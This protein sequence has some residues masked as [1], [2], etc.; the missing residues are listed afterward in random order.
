MAQIARSARI[1]VNRIRVISKIRA[2]RGSFVRQRPL[3]YHARVGAKVLWPLQ[4]TK[5][6]RITHHCLPAMKPSVPAVGIDLGTTYSAIARLDEHGRPVT[7][8]NEE[9]DLVTPSVVLFEGTNVVVGK[10]AVKALATEAEQVAECAKRDLGQRVYHKPIDG[11][12][13]PPEALQAWVLK[14]LVR[15]QAADRRVHA[16]W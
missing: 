6:K 16:R 1:R 2:I 14:K 4:Y 3:Q 5:E 13:Y 12:S 10:E 9:G 7:L 8:V 15:C 11:R